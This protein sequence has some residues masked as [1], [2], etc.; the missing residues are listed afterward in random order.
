[1]AHTV[2]DHWLPGV[3]RKAISEAK[4]GYWL[5]SP[6]TVGDERIQA[7]VPTNVVEDLDDFLAQ[8]SLCEGDDGASF[9]TGDYSA[10]ANT[11]AQLSKTDATSDF[12]IAHLIRNLNDELEA[13]RAA[14]AKAEKEV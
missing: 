5:Y 3:E 10:L 14:T 1:M 13:L 6:V 8:E 7:D 9:R 2:N 4:R 12:E 11:L